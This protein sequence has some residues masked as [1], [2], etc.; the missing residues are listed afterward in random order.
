[1]L[2]MKSVRNRISSILAKQSIAEYCGDTKMLE[3]VK[4]EKAKIIA[5]VALNDT[6]IRSRFNTLLQWH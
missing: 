2:N 5:E 6:V 3:E 1:M 4:I